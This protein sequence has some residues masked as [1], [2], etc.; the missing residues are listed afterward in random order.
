MAKGIHGVR[1]AERPP[2]VSEEWQTGSGVSLLWGEV[3]KTQVSE[4]VFLCSH[5]DKRLL[6]GE[7]GPWCLSTPPPTCSGFPKW[8]G[9]GEGQS[10]AGVAVSQGP[11]CGFQAVGHGTDGPTPAQQHTCSGS[12]SPRL[13]SHSPLSVRLKRRSSRSKCWG[14]G[15]TV[16]VGPR[17]PG[18]VRPDAPPHS[19]PYLGASPAKQGKGVLANGDDHQ[20]HTHSLP[21]G[22]GPLG[23]PHSSP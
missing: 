13:F 20:V 19:T 15:V 16:S 11:A 23:P 2:R 4:D 6:R 14:G 22:A 9:G 10:A 7:R 12:Y 3:C 17:T 1:L 18:P 5:T 8:G 21:G